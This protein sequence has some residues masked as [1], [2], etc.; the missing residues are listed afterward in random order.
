M[1]DGKTLVLKYLFRAEYEDG[2]II[3]QE[4]DDQSKLDPQRSA[5]YDVLQYDSK[6]VTFMLFPAGVDMA[7]DESAH[8]YEVDLIDG[9]FEIDG[10]PFKMHEV[11]LIDFRV[12]FFRVRDNH[13]RPDGEY[14]GND[15][16]YRI[17]FQANDKHT[18]KN[19]EHWIEIE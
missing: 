12:L 8:T 6:L 13:F 17:G 14:L 9:H 16:H 10:I 5:F 18:K 3:V 4:A 19:Y 15:T 7:N 11:E 1:P 2:H